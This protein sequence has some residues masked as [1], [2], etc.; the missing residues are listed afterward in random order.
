MVQVQNPLKMHEQ[1]TADLASLTV[2][3]VEADSPTSLQNRR[4]PIGQQW[5]VTDCDEQRTYSAHLS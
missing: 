5:L 3:G 1:N 2:D 4:N